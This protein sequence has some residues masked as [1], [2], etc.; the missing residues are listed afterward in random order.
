MTNRQKPRIQLQTRGLVYSRKLV[1][2]WISDLQFE[3]HFS[4]MRG[5]SLWCSLHH[6]FTR[7]LYSEVP[8][9]T[10]D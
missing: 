2:D 10:G 7:Q 9:M 5:Y 3:P 8:E 4:G 6:T 1:T